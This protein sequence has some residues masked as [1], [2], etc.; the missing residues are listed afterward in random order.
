MI[1][2]NP[3]KIKQAEIIVGI[4]SYNEAETIGF[5]AEQASQGLEKYFPDKKRVIINVDNNSPDG[6]KQA[7]F[8]AKVNTPRIYIS[9]DKNIKGKGYNFHNLFFMMEKLGAKTGLVLDADLKSIRPDW[10]NKMAKPVFEGYDFIAP[11]YSRHKTDATITNHLVY[12]LIYGLL[13]WDIRQPIGGDFAFSS[14]MSEIWLKKK[15]SRTTYQFGIDIFMS[16]TAFFSNSKVCQVNLGS[17]IHN[18]SNP[19]LG[20]MFSQVAGTLFKMLSK[21]VDRI[22]EGAKINNVEIKGDAQLPV[23]SSASLN[24]ESYRKIFWSNLDRFWP[25]IKQ[26]ASQPVIKRLRKIRR[27]KKNEIGLKLWTEIVYDFIYAYPEFNKKSLLIDALGCL[28]FG[29]VSQ[30]FI[31]NGHLTHPEVEQTIIKRAKY[32]FKKRSYFLEKANEELR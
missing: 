11:Y 14:K 17:K 24:N 2:D 21:N 32:F 29:R 5:V 8:E 28:Y 6:T 31:D 23:L 16:L 13:G 1:I 7:F 30:F 12:P 10:V 4:P 15:W 19:K 25:I 22:K 20:P 9:T 27:V 3:K 18:L 26:V